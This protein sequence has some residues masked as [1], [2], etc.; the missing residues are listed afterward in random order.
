MTSAGERRY[1]ILFPKYKKGGHIVR[2]VLVDCTYGK[3]TVLIAVLKHCMLLL[4]FLFRLRITSVHR[5]T[6]NLGR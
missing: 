1:S 3:S 4:L 6:E 2:K 5:A